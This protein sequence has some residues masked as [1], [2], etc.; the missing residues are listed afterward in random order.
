MCVFISLSTAAARS[1]IGAERAG[2]IN[3]ALTNIKHQ[4]QS[5]KQRVQL[6]TVQVPRLH[7]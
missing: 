7:R 5:P 2:R 3:L 1:V 4:K 6:L